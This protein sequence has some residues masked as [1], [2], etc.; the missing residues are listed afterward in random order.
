[1]GYR[2]PVAGL[3]LNVAI[4]TFEFHGDRVWLGSGGGIV[5]DS[6]PDDEY[7]ECLLKARPLIRAL[8]GRIA[9]RTRARQPASSARAGSPEAYLR[10]RPAAGIFTSLLVSD[11]TTHGLADHIA[12]LDSSARQLFGK[13]L[14][15]TLHADLAECFGRRPSG[16]LRITVRPLGGPLRATVE[17]VP[18]DACPPEADLYPTVIPGGLGR[19]K[20]LDRRLLADHARTLATGPGGQ[21]LIEDADGAVLETDRANVFAVISGVL[22]TPPAD[23]RL[24]PGV[25]RASVLRLA[26][27]EGI[28]VEVAPLTRDDL[29]AASELF[30]TNAVRGVLPVR[31]IA[32][33]AVEVRAAPLT[34]RVAAALTADTAATA[35]PNGRFSWPRPAPGPALSGVACTGNAVTRAKVVVIDNYDSF[36]Y[37]LVHLL[38]G[39]GCTVEVVRNDEVTAEQVTAS[40][41]AG[42]VISPGPCGPAEAGISMDVVRVCGAVMPVLGICLGHQA[43]A[44][45]YGARIIRAPRPVHGQTSVIAHD[46]R[47][48]LAGVPRRFRATRYHSL[49]VDERSLPP[50]LP[51]TARTSGGIPMGLRHSPLPIEGVQFHPESILTTHGEK[52]IRNFVQALRGRAS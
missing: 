6:Q 22:R 15:H 28:D 49:V 29:I 20:W 41:P 3:E 10:P 2:S 48:V 21:L 25:T 34:A 27:A 17:V 45:A 51:V 52:I 26:E 24:L 32:G 37:N 14:P 43:I 9:G 7:R 11:G 47:G 16:R 39:A 1:M 4:R 19:H 23:G 33:T 30:L 18:L 31:S 46:G 50:W 42:V 8:G 13:G 36:T 44:A 5:A 40:G 35:S 12:R 38:K